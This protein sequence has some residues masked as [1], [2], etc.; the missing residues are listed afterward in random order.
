MSQ[1]LRLKNLGDFGVN[2]DLQDVDLPP[3]F[4]TSGRNYKLLDGAIKAFNGSAVVGTPSAG[5]SARK[6]FSFITGGFNKYIVMGD[7]KVYLFDGATW[8]DVTPALVSGGAITGANVYKWS[9][10]NSGNTPIIS[11]PLYGP[12]YLD[13]SAAIFKP[14]PFSPTQT[15]NAK[16]QSCGIIRSHKA[17]LIALKPF[18]LDGTPITEDAGKNT[19]R[20]SAPADVNGLPFTW[21]EADL[22]T[23]A[24]IAYISGA[25][26]SIVD[27]LSLRDTFVIYSNKSIDMLNYVGGELI[28]NSQ[29]FT[30]DT[31]ILA[32]NC[33]AEFYN[34]HLFLSDTD[35]L[36]NDGNSLKSILNR[37]LK[38]SIFS[39]IDSTNYQRSFC[40]TNLP[41]KEVWT[42][43]PES[44][45]STPSL[46][47]IYNWET[48]Q[49][50]MR[51]LPSSVSDGCNGP[52]TSSA[53]TYAS[54]TY[55][56]ANTTKNYDTDVASPFDPT[57][58]FV[59]PTDSKLYNVLDNDLSSNYN[60][61]LERVFVPL[62]GYGIVTTI[63]SLYPI[64]ECSGSVLIEVG[65]S[66]VIG[67][68]I[69]WKPAVTFTPATMK[70]ADIRSTGPYQCWRIS[71][72]GTTPF[73]LIGMTIEYENN[74]RR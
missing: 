35:I 59:K 67:G 5:F 32:A 68:G 17:F 38:A 23:I 16:G 2:T 70:K 64:I 41:N 26:G 4:F 48:D 19:Y 3:E 33:V 43:I 13:Q 12:F 27:G 29:Q 44:G 39:K 25:G 50:Y 24:G 36:I 66:L 28:W 9:H 10:C 71:S 11:N 55:T 46:A 1:F 58:S 54:T 15:W 69:S 63:V 47:I 14:L 65:S 73:T 49:V 45:Q 34:Q 22:S 18:D 51:D 57:L 42:C 30:S 61:V 56:Y 31:G 7:S 6:I 62:N 60:T 8:T 21:E 53:E 72:I 37:K 20:W 74:G 52:K 40:I